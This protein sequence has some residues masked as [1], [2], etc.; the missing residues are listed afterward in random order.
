[1]DYKVLGQVAP[2][3]ATETDLYVVPSGRSAVSSSLVVTNRGGAPGTYRL[4]VSIGGVPTANESYLFYDVSVPKNTAVAIV[5]G[6]TAAETDVVRV[7][8]STA[9]FSFNLFGGEQ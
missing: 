8:A 5:L 6:I 9:N 2:L 1:M 3:A 4:S 7:Y